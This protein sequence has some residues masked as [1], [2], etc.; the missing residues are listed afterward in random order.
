MDVGHSIEAFGVRLKLWAKFLERY[1]RFL[2]FGKFGQIARPILRS[3]S[4]QSRTG[5]Q[6]SEACAPKPEGD[7]QPKERHK[8]GHSAQPQGSTKPKKCRDMTP[9]HKSTMHRCSGGGDAEAHTLHGTEQV[10]YLLAVWKTRVGPQ[11][12]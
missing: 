12:R 3:P 10:H 2:Y 4:M 5:R 7:E 8:V 9:N 1:V 11:A 6:Y